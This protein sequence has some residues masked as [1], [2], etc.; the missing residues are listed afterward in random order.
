MN[1]PDK[2]VGPPSPAACS[3]WQ[4]V[5]DM[6]ALGARGFGGP[7]A[8]VGTM[9][10]D[11]VETRHWISASDYKEGLALAQT[12]PGPLAASP[13]PASPMPAASASAAWCRSTTGSTTASSSTR[14]RSRRSRPARLMPYPL[15][16]HG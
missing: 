2:P 10:R 6:L 7:V 11:L 16:N 3:L 9:Y 8:L 13:R 1:G 12:M 4:L 5:R 15:T 14:W